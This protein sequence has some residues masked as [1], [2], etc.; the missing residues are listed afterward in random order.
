MT[1]TLSRLAQWSHGLRFQDVP[2]RLH[3]PLK[4]TVS[5]ANIPG[6]APAL[7]LEV[8]NQTNRLVEAQ[9]S[10]RTADGQAH[11][12]VVALS[13][14]DKRNEVLI[15][16]VDEITLGDVGDL[17]QP[18]AF[19]RLGAGGQNDPYIEVEAFGILLKDQA[20]YNCGDAVT[21]S[22]QLSSQTLSGYQI[23][24]YIRRAEAP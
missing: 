11:F 24:A 2:L 5:S 13:P 6:D 12:R 21:F 15:C 20:N 4:L 22:V 8:E 17:T 18:G 23:Y 14:G 10:W 9:L 16:P 1:A 3:E 19:V 7:L